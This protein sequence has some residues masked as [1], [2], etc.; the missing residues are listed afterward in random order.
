VPRHL[1]RDWDVEA[2]KAHID[3]WFAE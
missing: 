1:V 2:F 3:R